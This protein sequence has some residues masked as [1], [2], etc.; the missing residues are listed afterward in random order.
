[1][2]KSD[3][4][5]WQGLPDNVSAKF[6]SYFPSIL[7][8]GARRCR[9]HVFDHFIDDELQNSFHVAVVHSNSGMHHS[10]G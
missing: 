3:G 1:M 9:M 5:P 6:F 10:R 2:W 8:S 4:E 7:A